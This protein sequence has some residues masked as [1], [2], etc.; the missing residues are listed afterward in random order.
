MKTLRKAIIALLFIATQHLNAQEIIRPLPQSMIFEKFIDQEVSECSGTPEITIPL[1]DIELKGM[2]IPVFLA[3]HASGIKFRQYDGEVGAGWMLNIGGFRIMRTIF[4]K[5]DEKCSMYDDSMFKTILNYDFFRMNA[6]L[7]HLLFP[8]CKEDYQTNIVGSYYSGIE[9]TGPDLF[10]FS[11]PSSNGHFVISDRKKMTADVLE[12][13]RELITMNESGQSLDIIDGHGN[14]FAFGGELQFFEYGDDGDITAWTLK[15]LETTF[16]DKAEFS[17]EKTYKAYQHGGFHPHVLNIKE[18]ARFMPDCGSPEEF[19]DKAEFNLEFDESTD[20]YYESLLSQIE[21]RNMI[22]TITR[23]DNEIRMISV[24]DKLSGR[25]LRQVSLNYSPRTAEDGHLLLTKVVIS[26]ES[27]NDRKAYDMEYYGAPLHPAP[28]RWG[29]Y[30]SAEKSGIEYN[31]NIDKDLFLDDSFKNKHIIGDANLGTRRQIKD[32]LYGTYRWWIQRDTPSNVPNWF[33]LKSITSPTGERYQ[34]FYE[35]NQIFDMV[36]GREVKCGGIRIATIYDNERVT[37]FR[38]KG[39]VENISIG[40]QD[41]FDDY[42]WYT[43]ERANT[44]A[45]DISRVNWHLRLMSK[46]RLPE[47]ADYSVNYREVEKII[48]DEINSE[49]YG[50]H[51]YS[52]YDIP[53]RYIL[54]EPE[55]LALPCN[56]DYD[57]LSYPAQVASYYPGMKP[58]LVK[59]AYIDENRGNDTIKLELY[60]YDTNSEKKYPG[61]KISQRMFFNNYSKEANSYVYNASTC[62][63]CYFDYLHFR[64]YGGARRLKAAVVRGEII[65]KD[66]SYEYDSDNH[67]V[68]VISRKSADGSDKEEVRYVYS[69]NEQ[70]M[71]E[72]NIVD[73]ILETAKYSNGKIL[74]RN[75]VRY[76]LFPNGLYLPETHNQYSRDQS[77]PINYTIFDIYDQYGN[78]LQTHTL[79]GCSTVYLWGYDGRYPI[80]C[81]QNAKLSD[82]LPAIQSVYSTADMESLSAKPFSS[83]DRDFLINCAKRLQSHPLVAESLVTGY[84]YEP[85]MGISSVTDASGKTVLYD[86]DTVG[87]IICESLDYTEGAIKIKEYKYN[88]KNR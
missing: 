32:Y 48:E 68:K 55:S 53:E 66:E 20:Q 14:K 11:L 56:G 23:G 84:T 81:I 52:Y 8:L 10:T 46:P 1:F 28:D 13:T 45:K 9:D 79:D 30:T 4:G 38:Y 59:R 5:A 22:V 34:Y 60:S 17:Y 61:V 57:I 41:Y 24:K 39:G 78:P 77:C 27:G 82:I 2:T 73:E 71:K 83:S 47:M 18:A 88:Y 49:P 69:E 76:N 33:S 86:Y 19:E 63:Y 3:Y 64:I 54:S 35:P 67:L 72:R 87:R 15:T 65:E 26:G 37:S 44:L 43:I 74:G 36:S 12:G 75:N 51:T 31:A 25:V 40:V 80:A 50:F 29:Y 16:G 42:L 7:G 62:V 85:F 6:Y 70:G 21:T 58:V